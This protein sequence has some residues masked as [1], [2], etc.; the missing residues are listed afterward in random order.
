MVIE[1]VN[2]TIG[3]GIITDGLGNI[4]YLADPVK[5]PALILGE[6]GASEYQE[7]IREIKFSEHL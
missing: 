1:A 4:F 2:G 3:A 5:T 7:S 6:A